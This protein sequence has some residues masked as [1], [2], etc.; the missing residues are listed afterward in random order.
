MSEGRTPVLMIGLDAAEAGQVE[1]M[2]AGGELPAL[3][4]LRERGCFGVLE[5]NA[6]HFAGG[7]WPTFYTGR[8]VPG[9]G[10]YH[11]KLWRQEQMRCEVAHEAWLP[12]RPFW[13][14]LDR[15]GRRVCLLDVPMTVSA[16]KLDHGVQLS[17]WGT[18]DLIVSGSWPEDLWGGLRDEFGEPRMPAEMF[19]PQSR[20]TL[21]RLREQLLESLDQMARIAESLLTREAWDLSVVVLGATHRAGH[22]LWDLS[23][24]DAGGL[25]AADRRTLDGA[26]AAVYRASDRAVARLVALAP[27]DARVVVFALHGMGRNLGWADRCT[28]ILD[29]IQRGHAGHAAKKGV[30]FRLKK[31]VPMQLAREVTTRL[32]KKVQDRI[33]SLWS[34]SMY[35]WATTRHFPVPMDHAGYVRINLA[36]RE[37]QGVVQP[38]SE[39][40]ATCR[41]LRETLLGLRDVETGV[42]IV[43]E[44]VTLDEIAAVDAPY[45]DLLPD[46]VIVW[47]DL[48]AIDSR[49]VVSDAFGELRWDDGGRLPS[50]RSGNHRGKGWAVAAGPGVARGAS[51]EGHH[52]LDLAPTVFRWLD[53]AIPETLEG[54]PIPQL[55]SGWTRGRFPNRRFGDSYRQWRVY[56][57]E[58]ERG[59]RPEP[60]ASLPPSPALQTERSWLCFVSGGEPPQRLAILSKRMF[61]ATAGI[62]SESGSGRRRV[63]TKR[64]LAVARR[65]R[66]RAPATC[67]ERHPWWWVRA[68]SSEGLPVSG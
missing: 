1:R 16:P 20:R 9:H 65:G 27:D 26:L 61:L 35:D 5:S 54:R 62:E 39:Y 17:G 21:L 34:S 31:L 55:A 8:D 41:E 49:G 59:P 25:S 63:T 43:R 38:G 19:G 29:R 57:R 47:G 46:L 23:Q 13:E 44:V 68:R 15:Q 11:N 14:T 37:P 40:A 56:T 4:A 51:I 64:S 18:H 53:C 50:G 36:G 48:S 60:I 30:L 28:E 24:I 45:R 32:P 12:E 58:V 3:A 66:T 42:P 52:I 10:I 67:R 7:V 22:Y 6:T 2:M 33:V